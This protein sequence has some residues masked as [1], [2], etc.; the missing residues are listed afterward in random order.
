MSVAIEDVLIIGTGF[1]GLGMAIR[2]KQA[3]VHRFT[4]LEQDDGVGGTWRANQYPGAA[5]DIPSH[6]YSFSFEPNPRWT[7]SYGEQS[8]ILAYLEGCATKYGVLPHCRFNVQVT[9]ATFDERASVWEVEAK[10]GR[11]W[12]ARALVSGCGGLSRPSYPDIPGM[13]SY[14]GPKFHTAR[15]NHDVSLDGKTVGVV[16]TGASAIQ[17]VPAIAPKVGQLHLFQRTPPWIMPKPDRSIGA[18]EQGLFSRVPALQRL[19]RTAQYWTHEW[20]AAAFVHEPRLL[21][22]AEPLARRYLASRVRDPELRAKLTP[23]YTLG[24]KRILLSNDYYETLQRPNV[25]VVTGGI[26]RVTPKGVLT[27]G[28]VERTLDA[29]VLATGFQASE[30]VAPFDVR[31]R[32]GRSL[33]SEWAGGAEAYLGASVAGFPNFFMIIGP[34]T[35]LG[36]NSMR[37]PT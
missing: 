13:D 29:L 1:A 26:E 35:G 34:N 31:G 10:D 7:R 14:A 9:R 32:G 30:A 20:R 19:A 23:K 18:R 36:H 6:L 15:W 24:C 16:G 12:R 4:V 28:G 21:K 25:E 27:K 22:R 3:G 8:E 33:E 11:R 17:V 37:S 5:C 2:L